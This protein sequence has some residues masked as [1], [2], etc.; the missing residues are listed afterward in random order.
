M[1][2]QLSLP[3][4]V[5]VGRSFIVGGTNAQVANPSLRSIDMGSLISTSGHIRLSGIPVV[6][7]LDLTSL[8]RTGD[9]FYIG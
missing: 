8:E 6:D 5:E 1:L 4:V 7:K 9:H 3:S 2:V